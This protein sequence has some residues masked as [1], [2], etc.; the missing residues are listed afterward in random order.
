MSIKKDNEFVKSIKQ[1]MDTYAHSVYKISR[2]FIIRLIFPSSENYA[3]SFENN[4][5][6]QKQ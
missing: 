3:Y 5:N 1:K 4:L 2:K 6:I